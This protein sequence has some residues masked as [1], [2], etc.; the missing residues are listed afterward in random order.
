[1][2]FFKNAFFLAFNELLAWKKC[3]ISI[4]PGKY[5]EK[6]ERYRKIFQ[7]KNDLEEATF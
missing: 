5:L 3:F 2:F 7:K 6:Y 1:M 4:S